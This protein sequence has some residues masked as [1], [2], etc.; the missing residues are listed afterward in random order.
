M[1]TTRLTT[2]VGNRGPV[3]VQERRQHAL[4]E[5]TCGAQVLTHLQDLV[6]SLRR[7]DV[8]L[9]QLQKRWPRCVAAPL[10]RPGCAPGGPAGPGGGAGRRFPVSYGRHRVEVRS[11]LS[12][13]PGTPRFD[14][15]A[16]GP[17]PTPPGPRPIR[18]HLR[19]DMGQFRARPFRLNP[20]NRHLLQ[21]QRWT[22]VFDLPDFS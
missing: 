16:A 2:S 20:G 4:G 17:S 8:R 11:N 5:S 21:A 15:R 19:S 13:L 12:A 14:S 10:R 3:E 18:P 7:L 6:K 9:G 1:A 22:R